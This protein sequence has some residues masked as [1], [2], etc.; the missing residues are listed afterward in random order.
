MKEAELLITASLEKLDVEG[1]PNS[2][3]YLRFSDEV[4]KKTLIIRE[5]INIDVDISGKI[6]GIEL[7]DGSMM[8]ELIWLD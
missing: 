6:V 1:F 7:L 8:P 2:V 4:I 5:D 3:G